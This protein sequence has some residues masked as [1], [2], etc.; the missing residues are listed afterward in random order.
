MLGILGCAGCAVWA[1][2]AKEPCVYC[3]E[4]QARAREGA[5]RAA[6]HPR[7]GPSRHTSWRLA[8]PSLGRKRP[9][10]QRGAVPCCVAQ[11]ASVTAAL[12][13]VARDARPYVARASHLCATPWPPSRLSGSRADRSGSRGVRMVQWPGSYASLKT[14]LRTSAVVR[15][16]SGHAGY[17][18]HHL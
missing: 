3:G 6:R 11:C 18:R 8:P 17:I 2:W 14:V 13:P 12:Q 15:A 16:L 4:G 10:K 1:Q 5:S 7:Q 9:R